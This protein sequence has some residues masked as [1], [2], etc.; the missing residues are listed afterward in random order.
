[1]PSNELK[2]NLFQFYIFTEDMMFFFT[3][4]L[5]LFPRLADMTLTP[6]VPASDVYKR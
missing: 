3:V 6:E 4:A 2:E 5:L 1:M